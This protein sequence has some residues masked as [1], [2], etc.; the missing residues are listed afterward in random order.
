MNEKISMH[1]EYEKMICSSRMVLFFTPNEGSVGIFDVMRCKSSTISF[2]FSIRDVVLTGKY[3]YILEENK[4]H[5][6]S[7]KTCKPLSRIIIPGFIGFIELKNHSFLVYT[8][9]E[10]M[11]FNDCARTEWKKKYEH[12]QII[13]E[14]LVVVFA[15]KVVVYKSL[16]GEIYSISKEE[17]E[18][19]FYPIS[20]TL[21]PKSDLKWISFSISNKKLY[22]L[23]DDRI[24]GR[25]LNV[26]LDA[27]NC[28]LKDLQGAKIRK[29]QCISK[30][31]ILLDELQTSLYMVPKSL[32]N[33]LFTAKCSDFYYNST[34]NTLFVLYSK[35]FRIFEQISEFKQQ[36][37]LTNENTVYQEAE[38]EFDESENSSVDLCI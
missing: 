24:V 19:K 21:D 9:D 7:S 38:D 37:R 33:V 8:R 23:A 2:T 28:Q 16:D 11:L 20:R 1:V 31:L 3:I 12:A 15:D 5:K 22:L 14:F 4:I 32:E 27:L 17:F 10:A 30:A 25:D 18:E 6:Y 26:Y 36:F 13:G 35:K 29:F 34:D